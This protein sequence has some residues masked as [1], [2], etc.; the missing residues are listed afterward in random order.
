MI[1][2]NEN[3]ENCKSE[4]IVIP[5]IMTRGIVVLIFTLLGSSSIGGVAVSAWSDDDRNRVNA[6]ETRCAVQDEK[7]KQFQDAIQ[8]IKLMSGKLEL[9]KTDVAII[10]SY[11]PKSQGRE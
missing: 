7:N 5:M 2:Q 4:N 1:K 10:K 8:E 3:I 11:I 9:I 6:L